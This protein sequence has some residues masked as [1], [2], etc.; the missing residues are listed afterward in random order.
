MNKEN[1]ALKL[2]DEIILLCM[3][4]NFFPRNLS[5]R[6][7]HVENRIN[8]MYFGAFFVIH[9]LEIYTVKCALM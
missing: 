2:V 6:L 1:C 5:Y 4:I 8:F 3:F 7:K 9:L